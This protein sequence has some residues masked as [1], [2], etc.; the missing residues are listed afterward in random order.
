M[1]R[2]EGFLHHQQD[3]DQDETHG[4]WQIGLHPMVGEKGFLHHHQP[5]YNSTH[6]GFSSHDHTEYSIHICQE[7]TQRMR[8]YWAV[9]KQES[10]QRKREQ[11]ATMLSM[12]ADMNMVWQEAS[13]GMT[14]EVKKATFWLLLEQPNF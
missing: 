14:C 12:E 11:D 3:G 4:N 8:Q 13:K 9:T 5:L 7:A 10:H 1:P 2:E 6:I